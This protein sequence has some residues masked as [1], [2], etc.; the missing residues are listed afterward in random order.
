MEKVVLFD[1]F[2]GNVGKADAIIFEMADRGAEIEVL[3]VVD[4]KL[5]ILA[6]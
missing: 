5:V 3:D 1:E 4:G 6:R 2:G